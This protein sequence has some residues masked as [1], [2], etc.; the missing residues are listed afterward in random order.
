MKRK[1]NTKQ[2]SKE[3]ENYIEG[4]G[5]STQQVQT[6]GRWRKEACIGQ[7]RTSRGKGG[8]P[9]Q[10]SLKVIPMDRPR[11]GHYLLHVS[12][13]D[14]QFL[15]WI[16]ISSFFDI[17]VRLAQNPLF[18]F[19]GALL[20]Y[21]KISQCCASR[22]SS[23]LGRNQ[24]ALQAENVLFPQFLDLGWKE[25]RATC[26]ATYNQSS[27]E[28]GDKIDFCIKRLKTLISYKIFKT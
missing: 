2:E 20:L 28:L 14:F 24:T 1:V 9:D 5:T 22:L 3:D 27:Q 10:I 8:L 12:N 6:L 11:I 16:Q 4:E 15:K 23:P 26:A 19:A 17:L 18:L 25:K 21:E 7:N 13:F